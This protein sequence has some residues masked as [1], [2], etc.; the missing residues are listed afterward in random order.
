M[1]FI[2]QRSKSKEV[3]DQIHV[4]WCDLLPSSMWAQVTTCSGSVLIRMYVALCFHW[5]RSSSMSNAP[6][7]VSSFGISKLTSETD[8][9]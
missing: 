2:Q 9:I 5:K 6:G 8:N 3:D 7:M 1:D 4:I